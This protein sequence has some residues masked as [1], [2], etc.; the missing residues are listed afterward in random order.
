MEIFIFINLIKCK[1]LIN[2]DWLFVVWREKMEIKDVNCSKMML[3]NLAELNLKLKSCRLLRILRKLQ[4]KIVN[5][6]NMKKN[7]LN[8]LVVFAFKNFTHKKIHWYL[9]VSAM[10][11]ANLFIYNVYNDE[12]KLNLWKNILHQQLHIIGNL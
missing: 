10:A 5:K 11:Q 1:L 12:S 9:L 8:F 4:I 7:N 3:L 6:I 2:C